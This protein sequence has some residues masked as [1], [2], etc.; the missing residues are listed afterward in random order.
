MFV[1]LHAHSSGI[2]RCCRIP[3]DQVL[4]AAKNVGLGGIALTNHYQKY[5]LENDDSLSFAKRYVQEAIDAKACA[6]KMGMQLFFGVEATMHR[7]DDAHILLFG[8]PE[9]F[10]LDHSTL[11]DYTMEQLYEAVKAKNGALIQ[12]HPFRNGVNRLVSLNLLDGLELSCHPLY[13]GTH[14]N[15]LSALAKDNGLILTSGGDYHADTYR[16][17]CGIEIPKTVTN[18]RQLAAF[19]VNTPSVRLRVHEVGEPAPFEIDFI[20]SVGFKQP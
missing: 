13:D 2:S 19:L 6:K 18:E 20:R 8:I 9:D 16:A 7:Y 14:I 3:Y 15:T 11:Y 12:A 10:V 4:E 1:D 5:Y 17:Q